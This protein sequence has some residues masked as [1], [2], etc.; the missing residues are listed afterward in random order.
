M[1]TKTIIY[2]LIV[3]ASFGSGMF[4][5]SK[6]QKEVKIEIPKCP[7]LIH[8]CPTSSSIN[9]QQLDMTSIRKIKGGF[10]YSPVFEADNI[11]LVQDG[12][13]TKIK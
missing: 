12:D 8:K 7:D 3:L 6:L 5:Q 10:T 9:V 11:Y 13:T 2:A 4:T 1:N